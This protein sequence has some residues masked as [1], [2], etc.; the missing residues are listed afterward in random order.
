MSPCAPATENLTCTRRGDRVKDTAGS[1]G[2]VAGRAS[3]MEH[4]RDDDLITARRRA[5]AGGR[6]PTPRHATVHPRRLRGV[7]PGRAAA[8]VDG[9]RPAAGGIQAD[10]PEQ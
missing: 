7:S 1:R 10:A 8:A 6:R 4:P 5:R 2:D 3:W 9:G